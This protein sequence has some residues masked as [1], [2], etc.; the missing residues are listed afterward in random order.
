MTE[1]KVIDTTLRDAHQSLWATRMTTAMMLS[2]AAR[3]DR[4]GFE[5]IDLPSGNV[6]VDVGVRYLK[7]NPWEKVRL[8]CQ[9]ITRTPMF[10]GVLSRSGV[11]FHVVPDDIPLL[12]IERLVANGMRRFRTFDPLAD[13]DSIVP[14]LRFAKGL[15]AYTIGALAFGH[16]PVHTDELYMQKTKELIE[17]A[18]VDAIM[19]KDAGGLLTPDRIRTLVPAMKKV[20]GKL[21]LELHSHCITGLAPLVYLEGVKLGV[22]HVHTSIAPLANGEAQPATQTIVRNLRGMG[23]TVNVDDALIDEV[24][25]HFRRIAVQEGKPL[26]VPLEY[27]AFHFEHQV[28]GGMQSNF[29]F[30]LAQAGLSHKLDEVLHECA[31][32]RGE[33]G[34][35]IMIT[36]FSQIVGTQAVLNV[37]HGE[38]YRIVPDEVKKYALGYYGKLLAPADPDVRDRIIANGSQSIPLEPPPPEP[39]VPGLRKKYPNVSDE[40]RLLR[41]SY[42]GTQVD[43]MLAAGPIQTEYYFEK[44]IVRLLNELAK[45]RKPARIYIEKGSTRLELGPAR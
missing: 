36:P 19:L 7:E 17:R 25:E 41:Y 31:R 26:G 21:P 24:G 42:A 37:V 30:Q 43:E 22:D 1:I 20:M 2:V 38:R 18:G 44:P 11:G 3:M 16:S 23:Y 14:L 33:L 10:G 28:P 27:D 8:L 15:G 9:A 6:H 4:I 35:P 13:L 29:R 39:A 12:W 34:W 45:R 32:I 40:E 5:A